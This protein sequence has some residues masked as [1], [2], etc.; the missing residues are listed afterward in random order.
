MYLV[1]KGDGDILDTRKTDLKS[2]SKLLNNESY[3]Q[4]KTVKQYKNKQKFNKINKWI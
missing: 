4:Q 3:E 1:Q 2:I